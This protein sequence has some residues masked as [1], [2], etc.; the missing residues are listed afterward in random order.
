MW[1][2]HIIL[3]NYYSVIFCQ[4]SVNDELLM[5]KNEV[6]IT[7]ALPDSLRGE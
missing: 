3:F 1:M 5:F 2:E 6:Q 4:V 7:N